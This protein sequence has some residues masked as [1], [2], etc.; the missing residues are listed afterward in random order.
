M[1]PEWGSC[2]IFQDRG[3]S[4]VYGAGSWNGEKC[5]GL[6]NYVGRRRDGTVLFRHAPG[7]QPWGSRLRL[8]LA[9]SES[10]TTHHYWFFPFLCTFMGF[11]TLGLFNKSSLKWMFG[12]AQIHPQFALLWTLISIH[13]RVVHLTSTAGNSNTSGERYKINHSK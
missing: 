6:E 1:A 5:H 10:E 8:A 13:N 7:R 4:W 9:S 11:L 2:E 12:R 3:Q